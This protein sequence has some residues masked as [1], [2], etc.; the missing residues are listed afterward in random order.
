MKSGKMSSASRWKW[1]FNDIS[2]QKQNSYNKD[3][4]TNN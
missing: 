2:K 1:V 4:D 3:G